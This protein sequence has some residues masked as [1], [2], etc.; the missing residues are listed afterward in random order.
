MDDIGA[1]AEPIVFG[2]IASAYRIYD[3][4]ALSIM[5]DP[6][7]QATSGLVRFHAR[8]RTGGALVLAEAIRKIR[9]ATS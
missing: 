8:R 1:A 7:S 2:D 3:R 4:V 9:C 6:Y 5:R